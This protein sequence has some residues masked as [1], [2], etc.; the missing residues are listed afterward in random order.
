MPITITTTLEPHAALDGDL[1]LAIAHGLA[2]TRSRWDGQICHDG[3]DRHAVRLLAQDSY[4]AWL[5]GWPPGHHTTTHD[6]GGSTAA[7]V[8]IDGAL[9]EVRAG[10]GGVQRRHL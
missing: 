7:I 5:I 2:R 6:H 10:P 3:P 9:V 1:R 8:V 4:E